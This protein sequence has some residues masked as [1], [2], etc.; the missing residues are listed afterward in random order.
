VSE[1]QA[2]PSQVLPLT[3]L[4]QVEQKPWRQVEDMQLLSAVHVYPSQSC[5]ALL[6]LQ[7]EHLP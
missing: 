7:V 3:A 2:Y 1:E 5:P 6:L 4:L